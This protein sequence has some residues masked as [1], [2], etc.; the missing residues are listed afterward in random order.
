MAGTVTER[1]WRQSSADGIEAD[2][3]ALWRQV[4]LEGPVSRAV[5]SNLVIFCRC[6]AVDHI[7]LYTQPAGVPIDLIAQ[8]HPA[9]VILLHHDPEACDPTA[10]LAA[11][12]GL[13]LFGPSEARYGIELI[14]IRS[15]CS[16]EALPSILR[17][18]TL[19]DVPTSIWWTEDLADT[20][21]ITS[22]VTM[23]RQLVYDSRRWSDVGR[24]ALALAP[25]H[26]RQFGPDLAD[27][28]WRRA[29]P[30]RHA[31]VHALSDSSP[32][33]LTK[34][35]Q[36]RHRPGEAALAWLLAGWLRAATSPEVEFR[37]NPA[38]RSDLPIVQEDPSAGDVVL[39][40]SFGD[41]LSLQLADTH[42][43]VEG[44][45]RRASFV[46]RVPAETTAEAVADELHT[47]TQDLDLQ[48][49]LSTLIQ[50]FSRA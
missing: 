44:P 39:S 4:A 27:I 11:L 34:T 1:A 32:L 15:A 29:A 40:A 8:H 30:I 17:R 20:R 14:V 28:N 38:T 49:A 33:P 13:L 23:G 45:S 50:W 10:S 48:V 21:P 25:I 41:E 47:L 5:M 9:R 35:V 12:V 16:E 42:L 24:A 3:A 19:G 7:D 22:L 46:V 6:A 18:Y 31:L 37:S 43:V 2:L 26:G 36:I